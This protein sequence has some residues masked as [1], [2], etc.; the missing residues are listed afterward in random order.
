LSTAIILAGGHSLRIRT[1]ESYNK[2]LLQVGNKTLLSYQ[3]E[4][5]RKHGFEHF[6]VASSE[7]TYNR[8]LEKDERFTKD[9]I[10]DF[11]VEK[12]RLGTSGAVLSACNYTSAKKV[13][14]MN[15]DDILLDFNPRDLYDSL[16]RGGLIVLSKPRIGFG[17]VR[18]R[19]NVITRFQEKP[20][21][22]YWVSVGHY[23]FKKD[24]IR[25]YFLEEG[26]L[27]KKVLPKLAKE[28]LLEGY[29]IKTPWYTINTYEDYLTTLKTLGY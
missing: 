19:D 8:Y 15:V 21:I 9:K 17:L 18:M 11:S 20:T 12:K 29:K 7:E 23:T 28:R 16:T 10:I 3:I 26:D 4:W 22:K 5:L 25:D 14:I 6:I 27:E 24:I 2:A 13:Y 1:E